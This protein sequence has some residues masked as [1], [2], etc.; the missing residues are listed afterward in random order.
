MKHERLKT[1]HQCLECPQKSFR[2]LIVTAVSKG[3]LVAIA[4]GTLYTDIRYAITPCADTAHT[5]TRVKELA[6]MKRFI[7]LAPLTFLCPAL[8]AFSRMWV[9]QRPRPAATW[10][11]PI[12]IDNMKKPLWVQ[13]CT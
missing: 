12:R 1:G 3:F 4:S 6:A 13:R 2:F 5:P 10:Y 7:V 8:R 9:K 11:A